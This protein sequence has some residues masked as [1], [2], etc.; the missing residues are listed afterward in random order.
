[1]IL[2]QA[3]ALWLAGV[4]A[5]TQNPQIV[6][7]TMLYHGGNGEFPRYAVEVCRKDVDLTDHIAVSAETTRPT[8][9]DPAAWF[10]PMSAVWTG[11][12]GVMLVL[13]HH[14]YAFRARFV[15]DIGADFAV[16]PLAHALVVRGTLVDAISDIPHIAHHDGVGLACN[17]PLDNGTADFVSMSRSTGSCLAVIRTLARTRRL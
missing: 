16:I 14:P 17:S 2:L 12:A 9:I 4:P 8:G 6:R 5:S 7:D 15:R 11:L 3:T 1:M 13:Q 10:V